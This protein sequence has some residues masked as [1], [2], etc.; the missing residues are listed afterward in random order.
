MATT[1][2]RFVVAA[3][4]AEVHAFFADPHRRPQWQSSLRRIEDVS[5]ADPG[6]G[7]SW[8]DVTAAGVRPRMETTEHDAP[9]RWAERGTWRGFEA[10]L[11]MDL[12][13][14]DGGT[15]VRWEMRL[16]ATGPGRPLAAVLR[17]AAPYAIASDL[18]RAARILEHP[19]RL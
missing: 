16:G 5:P 8:V 17:R 19:P 10:W 11:G 7:Q 14:T 15:E 9:T 6:V 4:V 18:R 12:A 1:G 13:P 2:G 3:P